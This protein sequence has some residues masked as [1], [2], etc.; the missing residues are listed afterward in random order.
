MFVYYGY[1]LP[2]STR[3]ARGFYR[4]GI[5][6]DTGFMQWA[7]ISAV[8]WKEE[9]RVTL[10]LISHFTQHR[11]TARRSRDIS[12]ARRAGC[13]AIRLR[14]TRSTSAAPGS[15]WAAGTR[16]MREGFKGFRRFRRFRGSIGPVQSVLA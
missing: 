14:L 6:S 3:I 16:L 15:I 10:V 8:S 9:G 11:E 4:D 1:A 2:L 5:W 12:T 13:S 7:Q